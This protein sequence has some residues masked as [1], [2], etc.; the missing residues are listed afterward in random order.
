[1]TLARN[2]GLSEMQKKATLRY[3]STT[4]T[5]RSLP[6][7]S[8]LHPLSLHVLFFRSLLVHD[9]ELLGCLLAQLLLAS[10]LFRGLLQFLLELLMDR[11][12]NTHFS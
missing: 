12:N 10:K 11:T 4:H 8:H 6:D 5:P 9:G 3:K 1:M 7:P 2:I